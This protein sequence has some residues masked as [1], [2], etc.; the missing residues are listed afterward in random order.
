[1]V[2]AVFLISSLANRRGSGKNISQ[3]KRVVEGAQ[4]V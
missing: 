3:S 1:M 4:L 2:Q